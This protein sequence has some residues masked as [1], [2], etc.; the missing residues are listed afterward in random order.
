MIA[1][2]QLESSEMVDGDRD[3]D[4]DIRGNNKVFIEI[5]EDLEVGRTLTCTGRAGVGCELDLGH[6]LWVLPEQ[7]RKDPCSREGNKIQNT[8]QQNT[9]S[10]SSILPLFRHKS[11]RSMR[12]RYHAP[13][14][15]RKRSLGDRPN[16]DS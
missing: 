14:P 2:F 1:R 16:G 8:A 5:L 12:G 15:T 9:T 3:R 11:V 13:P 10:S 6:V 7:F 4:P